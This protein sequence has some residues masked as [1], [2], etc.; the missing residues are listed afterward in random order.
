[1]HT[2]AS[3]LSKNL[4]TIK[5]MH[6]LPLLVSL[7]LLNEHTTNVGDNRDNK[8]INFLILKPYVDLGNSCSIYFNISKLKV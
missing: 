3:H 2:Q 6:C 4:H 1:M 5:K 7:C 8:K